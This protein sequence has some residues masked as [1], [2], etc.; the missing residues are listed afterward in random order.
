[1]AEVWQRN[2]DCDW[3]PSWLEE[4]LTLAEAV[5]PARR[6]EINLRALLG[7]IWQKP[8]ARIHPRGDEDGNYPKRVIQLD[9]DLPA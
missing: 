7:S 6:R 5:E 8:G 3:W 2:H 4:G 9:G 1:V